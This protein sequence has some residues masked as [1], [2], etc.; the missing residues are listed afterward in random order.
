MRL[1]Q[2]RDFA[3][4]LA[5]LREWAVSI[6]DEFVHRPSVQAPTSASVVAKAWQLVQVDA[7]AGDVAVTF[8]TATPR[9]KGALIWVSVTAGANDA[10]IGGLV[11][12]HG[13]WCSNG[14]AWTQVAG[15]VGAAP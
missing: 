6:A 7:A 12:P 14:T 2:L 13:T 5:T 1:G 9:N 3:D 4:V 15:P 11:Y 10:L 8:E